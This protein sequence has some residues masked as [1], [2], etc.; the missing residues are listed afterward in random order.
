MSR[1]VAAPSK[2]GARAIGWLKVAALPERWERPGLGA[3]V[4][5][6]DLTWSIL[7]K[8]G[9]AYTALSLASARLQAE[10]RDGLCYAC[11]SRQRF[12]RRPAAG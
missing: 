11:W 6:H 3:I 12:K 10:E 1:P 8:C 7:P 4:A 9:H 5:S 2:S